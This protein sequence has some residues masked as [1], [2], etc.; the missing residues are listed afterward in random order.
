MRAAKQATK[1]ARTF[2]VKRASDE[3]PSIEER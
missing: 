2:S 1:S 3:I